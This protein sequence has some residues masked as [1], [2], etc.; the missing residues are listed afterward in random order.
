MGDNMDGKVFSLSEL[1]K[2][3]TIDISDFVHQKYGESWSLESEFSTTN[4]C[5]RIFLDKKGV[6]YT[7][8]YQRNEHGTLI[9]YKLLR[10]CNVIVDF[11][12]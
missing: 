10:L 12:N 2:L 5:I 11:K 7:I 3:S 8:E 6:K 9:P 1:N 4:G